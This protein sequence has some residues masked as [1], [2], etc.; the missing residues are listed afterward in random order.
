LNETLLYA[1]PFEE[2]EVVQSYEEVIIFYDAYELMEQ[3]PD[4]VGNHI[5][6]F[7]QVGRCRWDVG[8]FI[9]DRDPIYNIEASFRAPGK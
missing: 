2:V 5:D 3:P 9:I 7:I 4:I 1:F 6:E 8:C